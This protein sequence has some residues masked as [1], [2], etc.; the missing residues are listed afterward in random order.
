MVLSYEGLCTLLP[1]SR[2]GFRFGHLLEGGL[3]MSV[4]T[5]F[6]ASLL[7]V[8]DIVLTLY[9]WALIIGAVISWLIAF[10]VINTHNRLVQV[11]GDFLYRITEPALKRLRRYIPPVGGLDLTPL[12]LI[13]IIVFLQ[14]FLHSLV[15]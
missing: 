2:R 12:V 4:I 14:K 10:D 13:L 5:A 15:F 7:Y 8:V 6:L 3:T 1:L 11:V 9:I